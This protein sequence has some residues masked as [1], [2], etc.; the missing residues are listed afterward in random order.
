LAE[1]NAYLY[2]VHGIPGRDIADNLNPGLPI[3]ILINGK[4]CLV[5][6][7][8]FGNTSGPFTLAAG[9]YDV[10]ISMSN[11]LA[12]CTNAVV[13]DSQVTLT[14]GENLS[15]VAAINATQPALLQ[16]I[17]ALSPVVP[18]NARFV[19]A[20]SADAPALQ[21]TL[22]QVGV[23]APQTFTGSADPDTQTAIPVQAGTYLVQITAVGSTTVLTSQ[24]ISL[25]DQSVTYSYACGEALNNTVGLVNRAIR[26]VF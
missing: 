23:K 25:A 15:A 19:L 14:P 9:T 26:D 7:L 21:A 10:Q 22:T 18:G 1:S 17:D 2:V 12:P 16:F 3:D 11:T 13:I 20:N 8:T 6:G 4:S 5:R 24:Q